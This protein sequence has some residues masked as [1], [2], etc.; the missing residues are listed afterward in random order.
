MVITTTQTS[1]ST[2]NPLAMIPAIFKAKLMMTIIASN[3]LNLSSKN[4]RLEAKV[5]KIIS[6]RKR[7]KNVVSIFERKV[8]LIN[9]IKSA[10]VSQKIMKIVYK[11]IRKRDTFSKY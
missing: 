3:M 9:G 1:L 11:E 4:Q 6:A 10:K 8:S 2:P 5:F 7:A